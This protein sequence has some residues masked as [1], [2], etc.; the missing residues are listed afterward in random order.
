MT[1]AE[2]VIG[3]SPFGL[4]HYF[5]RLDQVSKLIEKVRGIVWAGGGFRMILHA[6]DRQFFV[7][8]SLDRSVIQIDVC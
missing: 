3:H 5:C 2:D 6:E 7:A 1:N 8:H 4:R